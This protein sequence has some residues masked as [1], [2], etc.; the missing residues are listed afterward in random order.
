MYYNT[1][2]PHGLLTAGC[3][4]ECSL[5]QCS[6]WGLELCPQLILD[7]K[8]ILQT[9]GFGNREAWMKVDLSSRAPRI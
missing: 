8:V 5:R 9:N 7:L 3:W 1:E 2:V 6:L 4:G